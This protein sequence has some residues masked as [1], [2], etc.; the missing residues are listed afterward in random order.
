LIIA[1]LAIWSRAEGVLLGLPLILLMPRWWKAVT[2]LVGVNL[3]IL[4]VALWTD[5]GVGVAWNHGDPLSYWMAAPVVLWKYLGLM[6]WPVN[7]TIDHPSVNPALPL[8]FAALFGLACLVFVLVKF[9]AAHPRLVLGSGWILLVLAPSL[10]L[11]N[12]DQI[13]ESRSYL[14][15]A[16]FALLV[17]LG[18]KSAGFWVGRNLWCGV[19]VVGTRTFWQGQVMTGFLLASLVLG[20]GSVTLFRNELWQDDMSLWKE[21][22]VGSPTSGRPRYNLGVALV[23]NGELELA[24]GAFEKALELA[25]SDD[26]SYAALGYCAE[27]RGDF[28]R[29]MWLYRAALDL[30][31]ENTYALS[32]LRDLGQVLPR[33]VAAGWEG[34]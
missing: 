2:A 30:N 13:N 27:M 17:A 8:A 19:S 1:Q 16:G 6:L 9:A 24:H 12:P 31:V 29:A 23:R 28:R 3:L 14:A 32:R 20:F 11:P 26:M 4:L 15:V 7:L 10:L 34:T 33:S 5:S 25:P 21:A 22:A 18:L